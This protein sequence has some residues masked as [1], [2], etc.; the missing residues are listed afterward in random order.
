[1]PTTCRVAL[2]CSALA[3]Y[4]TPGHAAL[5]M[6]GPDLIYDSDQ[7]L[8]WTTNANLFKTQFDANNG[9]ITQI[10]DAVGSV[11]GHLLSPAD[12][13][14]TTGKMNWYA[15]TAWASWLQYAGSSEWR[16][17]S[18]FDIGDDG[19]NWGY[20]GTDCGFWVAPESSEFAYLHFSILGNE[21]YQYSS[22]STNPN[23]LGP[24]LCL[25][26]VGADGVS[27]VSIETEQPYWIGTGLS[28]NSDFAWYFHFALGG[29]GTGGK[30]ATPTAAAYAW[31]VHDGPI[32]FA[33]SPSTVLLCLL[34]FAI[35]VT[36]RTQ[37]TIL[38]AN[39]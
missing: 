5:T 2:L 24:S 4:G 14:T 8:T 17:T 38:L 20:S 13:D 16:L 7:N 6:Q 31:A 36:L 35:F 29:Q 22:T 18:F 39:T 12:F 33:P 21:S 11:E 15:A 32:A 27:F 9:V 10:I 34:G 26:S 1:M 37:R 23:C 28:T 19:C 25:D 30:G 3:A